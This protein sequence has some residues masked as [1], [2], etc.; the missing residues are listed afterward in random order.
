MGLDVST[1]HSDV[2]AT[3]SDEIC[4]ASKYVFG[5][6][7]GSLSGVS[8]RLLL[9]AFLLNSLLLQGSAHRK[10]RRMLGPVFAPEQL[11]RLTPVFHKIAQQVRLPS[12]NLSAETLTR[13]VNIKLSRVIQ[14]NVQKG[15]QVVD[16]YEVLT[17]A[18]LE[19]VGQT[20]FG[21]TF[22]LF[23]DLPDPFAVDMKTFLCVHV[24]ASLMLTTTNARTYA[25]S[26]LQ[27]QSSLRWASS[28]HGLTTLVLCG[29]DGDSWTFSPFQACGHSRL[30]WT[31]SGPS[32]SQSLRTRR[33]D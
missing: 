9:P 24:P 1:T 8:S 19:T 20:G 17:R 18:A 4:R 16:M 29:S 26:G 12:S 15:A 6:S 27:R 31:S 10:Q 2:P 23:K 11:K 5:I 32:R 28:R 3:M 30:C 33:T 14:Q 13:R 7:L 22:G 25:H 21:Y